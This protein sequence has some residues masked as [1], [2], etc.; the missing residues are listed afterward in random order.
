MVKEKGISKEAFAKI[1]DHTIISALV[2]S[3]KYHDLVKRKASVTKL[4]R[5]PGENSSAETPTD[6]PRSMA[7]VFYGNK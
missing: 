1:T 2:D 7:D 3:A 5:D 6:T 4:V